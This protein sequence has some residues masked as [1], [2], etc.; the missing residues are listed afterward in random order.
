MTAFARDERPTS[1]KRLGTTVLAGLAVVV[2]LV[3]TAV[4]AAAPQY[5]TWS[6]PVGVADINSAASERGPSI[7]HD[8]LSLYFDSDRTGGYGGRDIWVSRRTSIGAWGAPVNAGPAIN[9]SA[10]DYYPA[11]TPDGHRMFFNSGRTGGLGANDIYESKRQD[12]HDDL[13]WEA[14]TR[15]ANVNSEANDNGPAYFENEGGTPQL[16]FGSGPRP[17]GLGERDLYVSDLQRDGKWG[18]P[19]WIPEL[20]TGLNETRP[21]IRSDG[22]EIFFHRN[23]AVPA[24]TSASDLWVA[25]RES[26]GDAWSA[27][28]KLDPPVNVRNA[29]EPSIAADAKT[30]FFG[31]SR[32]G[33]EGSFDVYMTTREQV[34]PATKDDCKKG[35]WERFGVFENQGDCVSYV[36]TGARNGPR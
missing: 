28:L 8:G 34:L 4:T 16:F 9:S 10:D 27:P 25:T 29:G 20:S 19:R 22:L 12:V 26:V 3:A 23:V 21:T 32:D 6:M 33:G 5:T 11:F 1:S 7:S 15:V 13:A 17:G 14:A 30:L 36:A 2:A 24:G 31:S 35:G 18:P